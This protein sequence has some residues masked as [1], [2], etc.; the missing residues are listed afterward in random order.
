MSLRARH[1]A[2]G[3]TIVMAALAMVAVVGG[4]AMVIDTGM[5]FIVQRQLQSAADAGALAGAWYDP[6]CPLAGNGCR[7]PALM[8][9]TVARDVAVANA[10]TITPLC[11]GGLNVPLPGTGT[12]L[13]LPRNVNAIV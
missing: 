12:P 3:Q 6:I 4:L 11:G 13:N 7:G 2:R 10:Q 9:Q 8:A 5:F 1:R